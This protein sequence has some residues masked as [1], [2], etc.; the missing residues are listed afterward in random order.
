MIIHKHLL[1]TGVLTNVWGRGGSALRDLAQSRIGLPG[2]VLKQGENCQPLL[3]GS[4]V[5]KH[6]ERAV[7]RQGRWDLRVWT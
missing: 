5:R 7:R 3:V 2:R 6:A 4:A 1:K